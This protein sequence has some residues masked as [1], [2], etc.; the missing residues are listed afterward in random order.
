MCRAYAIVAIV[1]QKCGHATVA[2]ASSIRPRLT[3]DLLTAEL[4]DFDRGHR[5]LAIQPLAEM[6]YLPGLMGHEEE[7]CLALA[8]HLDLVEAGGLDLD[9]A[10]LDLT[11]FMKLKNS[12]A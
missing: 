1:A 9:V 11:Q 2:H 4:F 3:S 12:S 8:F 5:A 7:R 6:R 10:D